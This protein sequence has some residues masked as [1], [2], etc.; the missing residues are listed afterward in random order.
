MPKGTGEIEITLNDDGSIINITVTDNGRGI[1]A[2]IRN[3]LFEPF[4]SQGK[5]NGTGLGLT[6][7]HKIIQD[8]GGEVT[9]ER[10]S[11]KGTVFH[12]TL[13]HPATL[14]SRDM[15]AEM[16]E[17]ATGEHVSSVRPV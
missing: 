13:P 11:P 9:L 12:I 10:T 14:T 3:T 17:T 15:G 8:H 7:V 5:E 16:D 2:P 6:V 4:V 1:P